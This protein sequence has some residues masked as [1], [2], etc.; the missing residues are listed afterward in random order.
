MGDRDVSQIRSEPLFRDLVER[1]TRFAWNLSIIMLVVY[2]G[3][4]AIIAFAPW[5][6]ATPIAGSVTTVGIPVGLLVIVSAFALTG[7]YV[8]R[9]NSVFDPLTHRI[10]ERI[11]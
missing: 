6:L 5:L 4:I 7:I 3:F 1:R 9:A 10:I 11:K 8:W 2:F